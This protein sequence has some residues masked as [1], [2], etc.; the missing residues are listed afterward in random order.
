MKNE[1]ID[2]IR[3]NRL[4]RKAQFDSGLHQEIKSLREQIV[5]ES[6]SPGFDP[7]RHQSLML[8]LAQLKKEHKNLGLLQSA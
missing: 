1:A 6:Y 4:A 3:K 5:R 8:K 2:N 7:E